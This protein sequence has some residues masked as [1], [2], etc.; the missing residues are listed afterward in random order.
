VHAYIEGEWLEDIESVVDFVDG[1]TDTQVTYSPYRDTPSFTLV[2]SGAPVH[3]AAVAY[4]TG[5]REVW[6]ADAH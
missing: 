2:D 1:I 4:C 3:R 6:V 5:G